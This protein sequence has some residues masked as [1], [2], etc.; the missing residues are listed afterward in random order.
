MR[1]EFGK[2]LVYSYNLGLYLHKCL[3]FLNKVECTEK[4]V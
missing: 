4:E 3:Y 2:S 1:A